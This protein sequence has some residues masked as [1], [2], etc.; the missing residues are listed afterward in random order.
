MSNSLKPLII[1]QSIRID[2]HQR[3][4]ELSFSSSSDVHIHKTRKKDSIKENY[5][6]RIPLNHIIEPTV[7]VDGRPILKVPKDII[8][9]VKSV[10][11]DKVKRTEFLEGV[12]RELQN[13][14][15]K[16]N[17]QSE[18]E[19]ATRIMAVFGLFQSDFGRF[20]ATTNIFRQLFS[21]GTTSFFFELDYQSR[22]CTIGD[23]IMLQ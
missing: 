20:D 21:D 19:I 6:I 18:I 3:G 9:E 2:N 11:T 8:K 10:L 12:Y 16:R 14:K 15:W 23:I 17:A 1:G 5:D 22:S 13:F 4:V 7:T